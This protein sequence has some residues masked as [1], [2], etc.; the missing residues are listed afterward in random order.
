MKKSIC[1]ALVAASCTALAPPPAEA[2]AWKEQLLAAAEREGALTLLSQPNL[3]AREFIQQGWS[4]AFPKVTLSLTVM[5][6]P[7]FLARFRTERS[8]GNYLWDVGLS[9]YTTGYI[10]AKEGG[11]DEVLPEIVDADTKRPELWGGWNNAFVDLG[12]KHVLS[13][14]QFPKGVY[15]SALHVPPE[16]IAA[17]GIQILLDPEYKGKAIWHNPNTPGSGDLYPFFL[18]RRIGDDG[19]KK[20]VVDQRIQWVQQQQEVVEAMVRGTAYFGMGPAVTGL[21]DQYQKAGVKLD[22]RAFGNTP[23][24]N[25]M[26]IGGSCL[27][28]FNKRPHP[29]ATRLFVNWLLSKDVQHGL[30]KAMIQNSRRRDVPSVTPPDETAVPGATYLENQREEYAAKA[31]AARDLVAEYRK[32]ASP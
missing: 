1:G 26:S 4:K 25:D 7:Q 17:R 11:V 13:L 12:G 10:L 28:V 2:Q 16:K 9:G 3:A 19:L 29:N 15:Y 24:L 14:S 18:Q 6:T 32:L 31:Q 30:A 5:G 20:L 23:E 21:L 8:T 27:Y 22:I